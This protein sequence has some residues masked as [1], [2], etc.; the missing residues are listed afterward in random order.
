MAKSKK[1]NKLIKLASS[2][3]LSEFRKT[4]K[5]VLSKKVAKKLDEKELEISKKIF[6]DATKK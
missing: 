5:E 3:N 6:K 4:L 2:K 1:L